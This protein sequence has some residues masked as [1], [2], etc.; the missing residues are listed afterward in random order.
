M[1]NF[2]EAPADEVSPG[3]FVI[4]ICDGNGICASYHRILP[5]CSVPDKDFILHDNDEIVFVL[6]G[7]GIATYPDK[8]YSMRRELAFYNPSGTP[9]KYWNNSQEELQ[10]M[11]FYAADSIDVVRTEKKEY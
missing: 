1:L 2:Y 6:R 7:Q 8:N 3:H 10:L 5:G 4:K 11:V 9:H